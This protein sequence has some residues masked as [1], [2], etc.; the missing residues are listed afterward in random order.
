[1]ENFP[2]IN[3]VMVWSMK[4]TILVIIDLLFIIAG[5][6]LIPTFFSKWK[7]IDFTFD[8]TYKMGN[9]LEGNTHFIMILLGVALVCYAIFDLFV[10]R[11]SSKKR[12]NKFTD[13]SEI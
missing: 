9:T 7:S 13:N 1:M 10:F 2:S 4:N 6:F 3:T 5:F 12:N 11:R 8:L